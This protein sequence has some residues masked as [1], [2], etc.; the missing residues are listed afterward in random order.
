MHAACGKRRRFAQTRR[1]PSCVIET[2]IAT[3]KT[4]PWVEKRFTSMRLKPCRQADLPRPLRL[5]SQQTRPS[6]SLDF[7]L[8]IL[9]EEL[10]LHDDRHLREPALSKHF[11][12]TQLGQIQDWRLVLLLLRGLQR[13]L[14]EEGPQLVDV[15]RGAVLPVAQ[16]VVL[17]HT[18]L[19]EVAR[20]ILVHQRTV[21]VLTTGVTTATRVTSVLPDTAVAR[22][23]VPA[24]LPVLVQ[25]GW[26]KG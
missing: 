23:H 19:S 3:G 12:Q 2:S 7:L 6:H 5:R 16:H 24:F 21:V 1:P 8:R 14:G 10:C 15:H 20:V 22:G 4:Q 11:E 26:L 13:A 18:D 25:T 17:S 9:R